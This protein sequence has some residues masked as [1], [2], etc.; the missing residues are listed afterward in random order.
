MSETPAL[1]REQ[2]P[3]TTLFSPPEALRN[4]VCLRPYRRLLL[5]GV[6]R[7][8][9]QANHREMLVLPLTRRE[10][11]HHSH[12]LGRPLEVILVMM[13]N[14]IPSTILLLS[15]GYLLLLRCLLPD[16]QK[17]RW[18]QLM[19]TMICMRRL[20]HKVHYTNSRLH[21]MTN[22]L[23]WFPRPLLRAKLQP[24]HRPLWPEV[25]ELRWI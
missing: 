4:P 3:T 19:T 23:L 1:T 21:S 17:P 20:Q 24:C 14:T 16:V 9:H 18:P 8:R 11:H 2:S 15:M 13:T 25:G 10:G 22:E 12:L 5:L 7:L 6:F